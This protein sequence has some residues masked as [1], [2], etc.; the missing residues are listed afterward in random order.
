LEKAQAIQ[1]F[2]LRK[3]LNRLPAVPGYGRPGTS[4]GLRQ[5]IVTV[6]SGHDDVQKAASGIA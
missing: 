2:W 3:A 1:H 5:V 6:G 4:D